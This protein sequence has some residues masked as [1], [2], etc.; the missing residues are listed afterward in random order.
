MSERDERYYKA[1]MEH[2]TVSRRGLFRG[3]F[4]GA[5]RVKK[6]ALAPTVVRT[7]PRPP[8]AIDEALFL[9]VCQSCDMCE[10][11][12]PQQVIE[13]PEGFPQLNL[14]YNDCS[15]CG[16]CQKACP[17]QALS[18]AIT[19]IGVR[20]EFS[21]RCANRLSGYCELCAEPC[22]HQAIEIRTNQMPVV[23]DALCDGC[24]QC[25][26]SCYSG[27]ITMAFPKD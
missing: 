18:S 16:E 12:C 15:Q 24:G 27:A 3:L 20:P 23:N 17:T 5:N 14:E 9:E 21:T 1:C 19:D 7:V 6:E 26:T 25:R 13:R 10:K 8:G 4:S 2:Y 22:P 11:A